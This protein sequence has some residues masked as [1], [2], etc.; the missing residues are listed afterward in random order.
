MMAK[1][2]DRGWSL[3][4]ICSW[5]LL[6][7]SVV[8]FALFSFLCQFHLWT[9]CLLGPWWVPFIRWLH[10]SPLPPGRWILCFPQPSSKQAIWLAHP[11]L[12]GRIQETQPASLWWPASHP[13]RNTQ[14]PFAPKI[15]G[16]AVSFLPFPPLWFCSSQ[17][18]TRKISQSWFGYLGTVS[19][20]TSRVHAK[21]SEWSRLS[22]RPRAL[23][24]WEEHVGV[25]EC[26]WLPQINPLLVSVYLHV[27]VGFKDV[28]ICE[29]R[30]NIFRFWCLFYYTGSF[31]LSILWH[32]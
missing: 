5:F 8:L 16:S 1:S 20:Q 29:S 27:E 4:I 10:V 30:F 12:L 7:F 28:Y 21:L 25:R 26:Q 6:H 19:P 9:R 3:R 22:E 11:A 23:A 15:F 13:R 18:L 24:C 31:Q 17:P 14:I 2:S 32:K